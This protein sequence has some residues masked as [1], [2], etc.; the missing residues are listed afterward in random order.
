MK[1]FHGVL[2]S[3]NFGTTRLEAFSDGVFAI[4]ITLLILEVRM[5]S[6][7][8]LAAPGADLSAE[9]WKSL[10]E[11]GPKILSYILSFAYV[12]I[13]WVNHHQLF[14]IIQRS[15][16]GLFWCNSLFLMLL[17]FIPFPTALL[18]E[19][20]HE[21]VAVIFYG[22]AMMLTAMSFLL[23]K[24]YAVDIGRLVKP[25]IEAD[26]LRKSVLKVWAGP[27][28]YMLAIAVSFM[29]TTAAIMIYW[30][31]PVIYFFPTKLEHDEAEAKR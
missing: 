26:V 15:D 30:I 3:G 12:S 17:A 7:H 14:H 18:G 1:I 8:A 5:P 25:H 27:V 6:L 21:Y 2:R 10:L 19:Y 31:I 11:L 9:L 20:S 13:Y 22:V 4:V 28:L 23:M 16:R 24:W 29:S